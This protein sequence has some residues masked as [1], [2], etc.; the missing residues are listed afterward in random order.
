M[1]PK[2]TKSGFLPAQPCPSYERVKAKGVKSFTGHCTTASGCHGGTTLTS[3]QEEGR[4]D[5]LSKDWQAG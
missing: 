3:Q 5:A 1:F 2:E 4:G